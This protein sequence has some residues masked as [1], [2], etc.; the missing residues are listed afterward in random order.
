MNHDI[1]DPVIKAAVEKITKDFADKGLVVES[2]WRVYAIVKRFEAL[3]NP[4]EDELRDAF[5]AGAQ[6]LFGS[7]MAFLDPGTQETPQDLRRMN[8]L[9][10]EIERWVADYKQRNKS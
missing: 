3:P 10:D 1:K 7:L 8:L 6:H 9:N 2:G 5:Y 4:M